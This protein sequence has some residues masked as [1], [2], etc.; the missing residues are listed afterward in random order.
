[1]V[2]INL[3]GRF[4]GA[5]VESDIKI[6][7]HVLTK[8][9]HKV[10]CT[11]TVE[12]SRYF[13]IHKKV[14]FDVNLFI[15]SPEPLYFPVAKRNILKPNQEII[16][17]LEGLDAVFTKTRYAEGIF[18]K[19]GIKTH[20][21]GFSSLDRFLPNSVKEPFILH[22]TSRSHLKGTPLV[23]ETWK[24]YLDMP[25]LVILISPIFK[26]LI[27][28][29]PHVTWI[30]TFLPEEEL[31]LLQNRALYHLCPS[32]TEGFGHTIGEALS[33]GAL[34]ITT[35]APPM[36]ELVTEERGVLIPWTNA[37]PSGMG[38]AFYSKPE[39][40]REAVLRAVSLKDKK[41]R[42]LQA[43]RFFENLENSLKQHLSPLL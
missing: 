4:N 26:S 11:N 2:L 40:L 7:E 31:L 42:C 5:G 34:V 10:T 25:H 30:N 15:G 33:T 32:Y 38:E 23:I 19:K 28:D 8:M 29:L 43:R 24:K 6:L 37:T 13:A 35:N 3:V 22:T 16:C 1:M 14:L 9:G 36:N 41:Q 17:S 27:I 21:I 20:Y 39:Q 18:Q 12:K